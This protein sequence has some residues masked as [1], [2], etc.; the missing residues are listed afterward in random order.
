MTGTLY[1]PNVQ[2]GNVDG[3]LGFD[4][5]RTTAVTTWTTN[6]NLTADIWNSHI[7][8]PELSKFVAVGDGV[9]ATSPDGS[10]WT[11]QN[12]TDNDWESVAWS[13]PLNKLAAVS[14]NGTNQITTSADGIGWESNYSVK[15]EN[16][17]TLSFTTISDTSMDALS[18]KGIVWSAELGI[19]VVVGGNNSTGYSN[20][21]G[22]T[23]TSGLIPGST[24]GYNDIVWATNY[25][26]TGYN[27]TLGSGIFV[28]LANGNNPGST[29]IAYS[30]DG[31]NWTTI[32]KLSFYNWSSI[33]YDSKFQ[34]FICSAW[35]TPNV[36]YSPVNEITIGS[37]TSILAGE[38]GSAAGIITLLYSPELQITVAIDRNGGY[39]Q[40][41][42]SRNGG[43]NW[44]RSNNLPTAHTV[45]YGGYS[46]SLKRFVYVFSSST[47]SQN[48][49]I[50]YSDDG[51]TFTLVQDVLPANKNWINPTWSSDLD[52]F[53]IKDMTS[54]V[55]VSKDGITWTSAVSNITTTSFSRNE[56]SPKYGRF[57]TVQDSGTKRISISQ[58]QSFFN[59]LELNSICWSSKNSAFCAISNAGE[60]ELSVSNAGTGYS[61]GLATI[62]G[63]TG[64]NDMT[65]NLVT[66]SGSILYVILADNGTGYS[67]GDVLTVVKTGGSSGTITLTLFLGS[68]RRALTSSNGTTWYAGYTPF[69]DPI[70][71]P[72]EDNSWNSVCW[73]EDLGMFVAVASTG[74]NRIMA[75]SDGINWSL[76][77]AT[78][79]VSRSWNSVT[80][81]PELGIFV[82]VGGNAAESNP[83]VIYSSDS[84]TW[85]SANASSANQ[86]WNSVSWSPELGIFV[87][88]SEDGGSDRAMSSVDGITWISRPLG[89]SG[90]WKSIAWSPE[91]MQ[92]NIISNGFSATSDNDFS[93]FVTDIDL[94]TRAVT[95]TN[96]NGNDINVGQSS[97]NVNI[98]KYAN[99]IN[100]GTPLPTPAEN[101]ASISKV[102][103]T[104]WIT[105]ST[106]TTQGNVSWASIT[107]SERLN[108]FFLISVNSNSYLSSV[109]GISW[110]LNFLIFTT[111]RAI[112][113]AFGGLVA[114]GVQAGLVS[115]M[116]T[117]NDGIN[118][119]EL[120]GSSN[121]VLNDVAASDLSIVAVGTS[122]VATAIH[123]ITSLNATAA[124]P[125]VI[126]GQTDGNWISV[127]Y[128]HELGLF[129]VIGNTGAGIIFNCAISRDDGYNWTGIENFNYPAN[130]WESI[131]WS[132]KL[133][134]FCAVSSTATVNQVVQTSSDGYTW[135]VRDS[136][137][138]GW[139]K[140]IWVSEMGLFIVN[141][142][143]TNIM[144]SPDGIIWT[145]SGAVLANNAWSGMAWSPSLKQLVAVSSSGTN[146]AAVSMPYIVNSPSEQII[147]IRGSTINFDTSE[148]SSMPNFMGSC[149]M[150]DERISGTDGGTAYA[151]V[152]QIRYLNVISK[153]GNID[154]ELIPGIFGNTLPTQTNSFF[155]L[156]PGNYYINISAPAFD[157]NKHKIKLVD[158]TNNRDELIGTSEYALSN[159]KGSNRS[160]C[161][162]FLTLSEST[163]FEVQH[164]CVLSKSN[165]GFGVAT[166]DGLNEVYTQVHI[167]KLF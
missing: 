54:L 98:G 112:L 23:W 39:N 28:A 163:A 167:N 158:T 68:G 122:S 37:W 51:I 42:Y 4:E 107:W 41:G 16:A 89:I 17:E 138:S 127:T 130:T 1:I 52:I 9:A 160:F 153:Y 19:F 92:M 29:R 14:T 2:T 78:V 110:A 108:K 136:V 12:I 87:A 137:A 152:W 76:R 141:G 21:G 157:I 60:P 104:S 67:I 5:V 120:T 124:T 22:I 162:G 8:A 63:G 118:W 148:F 64:N 3:T 113:A 27:T 74:T 69:Y 103:N 65:V 126:P 32:S 131:A 95:T 10:I 77:T 48:A 161:E 128:A 151:D 45:R 30:G 106:V 119:N 88:I 33:V 11:T 70:F 96:I 129:C 75:S 6:N 61:D 38:S 150:R 57:V 49:K 90:A 31:V 91:L 135:T 35:G 25:T 56:W 116:S 71:N 117:S 58:E 94:G 139:K 132:S 123:I 140:I 97:Q 81:S 142:G 50:M 85:L 133:G 149:C 164:L 43:V 145:T 59:T 111:G 83:L 20:D 125:G 121:I 166:N 46:S 72:P 109:D 53:M 40:S 102:V 105:V 84:I 159:F 13:P 134:M 147:N 99:T 73:S 115:F 86:T 66:S 165:S 47:T 24:D 155:I 100:I 154:C 26:G 36:E 80:W 15:T 114:V 101:A 7:Y 44:T 62:T 146:R 144:T 79:P 93:A 18:D 55:Y 34:R 82:A 156:G 143:S